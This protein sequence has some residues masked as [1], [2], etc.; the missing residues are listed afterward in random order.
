MRQIKFRA[1]KIDGPWVIGGGTWTFG[2]DTALFGEDD[3]HHPVVQ[4]IDPNT[5]GAFIGLL[6]NHGR[7][8][9]EGDIFENQS[10]RGVIEWWP[11]HCCFGARKVGTGEMFMITSQGHTFA[12]EV[13]G[14]VFDNP[15]CLKG[16]NHEV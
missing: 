9:Y 15:E 6:D 2:K 16:E 11:E 1:K 5:V 8:I 10:G 12:T 3:N 13:I 7:E 14:N 4:L